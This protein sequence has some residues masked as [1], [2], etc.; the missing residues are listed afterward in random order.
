MQECCKYLLKQM[1]LLA[2]FILRS[3]DGSRNRFFALLC[4]FTLQKAYRFLVQRYRNLFTL[5]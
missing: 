3:V 1:E 2:E 4:Q 5:H